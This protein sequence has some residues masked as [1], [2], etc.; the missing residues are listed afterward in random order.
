MPIPTLHR[1]KTRVIDNQEIVKSQ[2][3]V[4]EM[5]EGQ[6][7]NV[8][9]LTKMFFLGVLENKQVRYLT[10]YSGQLCQ[11]SI[12]PEITLNDSNK[13]NNSPYCVKYRGINN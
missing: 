11:P 1:Q 4:V 10:S 13:V 9:L 5:L 6:E 2:P 8:Q 12:H 3:G 7:Y